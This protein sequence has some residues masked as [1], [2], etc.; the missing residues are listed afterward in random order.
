MSGV[1]W[2]EVRVEVRL[3]LRKKKSD[4]NKNKILCNVRC[5]WNNVWYERKKNYEI[6][7]KNCE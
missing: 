4:V 1:E 6:R 5:E 3:R 2:S 7:K